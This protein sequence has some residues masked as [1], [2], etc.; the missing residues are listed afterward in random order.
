VFAGKDRITETAL[1]ADSPIPSN[2]IYIEV[3]VG[4]HTSFLNLNESATAGILGEPVT[5]RASLVDVSVLPPV[6]VSG[7]SIQFTLGAANCVGVSDANG[8]A[9][10]QLTPE[11]AGTF[12][13]NASFAGSSSLAPTADLLMFSVIDAGLLDVLLLNGG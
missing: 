2:A 13:L 1:L 11:A 12:P 3:A 6:P 4:R 8:K 5:V 7:R 9:S 10:C